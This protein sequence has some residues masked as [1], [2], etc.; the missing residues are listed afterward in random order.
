MVSALGRRFE[1]L[2]IYWTHISRTELRA[3]RRMS[4]VQLRQSADRS[5]WL[6]ANRYGY[7]WDGTPEDRAVVN[8]LPPD[9]WIHE[10]NG[11]TRRAAFYG[12]LDERVALAEQ[13][14]LLGITPAQRA[15]MDLEDVAW[16]CRALEGVSD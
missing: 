2:E 9:S 5:G 6:Q 7:L 12:P 8:A 14:R 16:L 15:A 11:H 10:R 13:E 4:D 1:R 3:I